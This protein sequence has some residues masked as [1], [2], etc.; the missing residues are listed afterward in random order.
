MKKIFKASLLALVLIFM[1]ACSTVNNLKKSF[2]TKE[3]LKYHDIVATFVTT[4]GE[5]S[6][7]L[8][9][10]AAPT[11]VANFINL[12]KRGY[13]NDNKIFREVENFVLQTGDPT[14]TG[15]GNTGYFMPEEIVNWLNFY[16]PGMLAMANAGPNTGSSQYFFSLYPA[17]WLNGRH[18]IF[19]EIKSDKD[20]EKL[21][22][23][24]YGDV[25]KEIKFTGNVDTFL[26]LYKPLIVQW[27]TILDKNYPNLKKYE[28]KDASQ[29]DIKAYKKELEN[30]YKRQE[31]E[32]DDAESPLVKVI[33]NTFNKIGHY[34][35]PE[36]IVNK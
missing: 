13:Y 29:E 3:P 36:V 23:L 8:Y 4:Q 30:I 32:K 35:A 7:F 34:E 11:T 6:F 18:T 1:V 2:E 21:R 27:N 33:R 25:I 24:E 14:E 9:P 17:D 10:E 31:I 20:F 26:S 22:K 12:A 16:Q 28:I 5:I 15:M 19:G